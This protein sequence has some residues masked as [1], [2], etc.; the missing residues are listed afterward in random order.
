MLYLLSLS[1]SSVW[2]EEGEKRQREYMR[3]R[4]AGKATR[5]RDKETVKR[6]DGAS[7]CARLSWVSYRPGSGSPCLCVCVCVCARTFFLPSLVP[8]F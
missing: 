4:Q 6:E 7:G 2:R 1:S 3:N 8:C 5:G